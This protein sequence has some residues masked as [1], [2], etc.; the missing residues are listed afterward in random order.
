MNGTNERDPVRCERMGCIQFKRVWYM[1]HHEEGPVKIG[2]TT[3]VDNL[4]PS[5]SEVSW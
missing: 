2:H 3:A 1:K 4:L 5:V